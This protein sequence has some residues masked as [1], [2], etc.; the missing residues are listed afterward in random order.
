MLSPRLLC[1]FNLSVCAITF[2]L[3]FQ[4]TQKSREGN[5]V[6]CALEWKREVRGLERALRSV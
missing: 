5:K 3:L 6:K 1:L 4:Y 2:M